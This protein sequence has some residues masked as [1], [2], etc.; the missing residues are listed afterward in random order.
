MA[1]NNN[2]ELG[3]EK[4]TLKTCLCYQ[5]IGWAIAPDICLN[6]FKGIIKPLVFENGE[7]FVR[8]TYIMYSD[9]VAKLPQ[10]KAFIDVIRNFKKE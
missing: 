9:A 8:S 2:A 4:K 10:I 5:C 6:D 7:P 3:F 1:V